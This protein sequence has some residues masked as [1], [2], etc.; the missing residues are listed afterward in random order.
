MRPSRLLHWDEEP[1]AFYPDATGHMFSRSVVVDST[2]SS[3]LFKSPEGGLVAII[4]SNGNGQ[5][6]E[7]AYSEDEV[8][9]QKYDKVVAESKDPFKGKISAIL[10]SSVGITNGLWSLLVVLRIYSSQDLKNWQVKQPIRICI[11]NVLTFIRL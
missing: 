11:R 8:E 6:I 5:R 4:T 10:R 2:N 7:I 3:G 1:I 9:Q